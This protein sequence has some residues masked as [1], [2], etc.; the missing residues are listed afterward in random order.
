[1]STPTLQTLYFC[2][3]LKQLRLMLARIKVS[4]ENV[5]LCYLQEQGSH[6]DVHGRLPATLLGTLQPK[7]VESQQM[8]FSDSAE[9]P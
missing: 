5:T 2:F 9:I 4:P 7:V 6:G 8:C 3:S 1:M